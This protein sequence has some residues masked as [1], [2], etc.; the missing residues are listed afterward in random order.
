MVK[1]N[2][3]ELAAFFPASSGRTEAAPQRLTLLPA[4]YIFEPGETYAEAVAKREE[5]ARRINAKLAAKQLLRLTAEANQ[6]AD[7]CAKS[8]AL[9]KSSAGVLTPA[10]RLPLLSILNMRRA[11]VE[12]L[13]A[14]VNRI[15]AALAC[16]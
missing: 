3:T 9:Y 13:N 2:L 5:N 16:D 15:K 8:E 11:K 10:G 12:Q 6:A 1:S 4:G 7:E 14:E